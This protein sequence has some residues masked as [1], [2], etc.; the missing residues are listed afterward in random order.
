MFFNKYMDQKR[1]NQFNN[2]NNR[3]PTTINGIHHIEQTNNGINDFMNNGSNNNNKRLSLS[4][5][6]GEFIHIKK[7][8]KKKLT[9]KHQ[10][11]HNGII[12]TLLMNNN[13]ENNENI[14]FD[15]NSNKIKDIAKI[16][17]TNEING[18]SNNGHGNRHGNRHDNGHGNDH[19]DCEE[20]MRIKENKLKEKKTIYIE[21]RDICIVGT[22]VKLVKPKIINIKGKKVR[23]DYKTIVR[24]CNG[25]EI[26]LV[27]NPYV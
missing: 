11:P 21:N 13:L 20:C 24:R 6:K 7:N 19:S 8:S 18:D 3:N 10:N 5:L 15:N 22:R 23:F 14:H 2:F 9:S 26:D 17:L 16:L 25:D 12:T 27:V 1:N 4:D